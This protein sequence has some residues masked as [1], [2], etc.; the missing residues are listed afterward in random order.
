MYMILG[1]DLGTNSIGWAL[2]EKD[3]NESKGQIVAAGSRIIPMSQDILGKFDSG[4][5][6]SQTAERT[7]FRA[8]RRMRERQLLRRERLHRVLNVIGFLPEHY[9]AQIDF[10][11]HPG[12][13]LPNTEPKLPYKVS[14][15]GRV[16]FLFRNSFQEMLKDFGENQPQLVES[17]KSVPYDWTIYY[18][19]KKAL[20]RKIEKQELAWL[21]LQ[22]NQKRGYHQLRGEEEAETKN[23]IVEFH[24]LRVAEVEATQDKK[25][26]DE[27]W[28]N[29]HLEN[30]WIYKRTSKLPLDW[31]GK[32]KEF[33]VTTDLNEDGSVKKDKDGKEKRSLR[34]PA[35]E[36][37]TLVKKKTEH[38]LEKSQKTVGVYI[39]D[40]LLQ[41]PNQKIKGKLIR[42]VERSFYKTEL[43][44]IL[45]KQK[46]FHQELNDRNI[47]QLCLKELY[48]SNTIHRNSIVQKDIIHLFINDILF[49]QR[50]LKSK[51][52][53]ISNCK[54]ERRVFVQDGKLQS[55]PVKAIAKSNPLFQEFRLWKFVRSLRLYQL[56]KVVGNTL[57]TDVDVTEEF[58]DTE[59]DLVN[60]FAWL[61][62]KKEIDQKTF[63]KYPGFNLKK[64]AANYRWNYVEDRLYPCNETRFQIMSRLS[65]IKQI[66]KN[67]LN[68]EME[69]ALWHI[70][71]SVEDKT[72]IE[73]ALNTFA[74]R[75]E[76]GPEFVEVFRK[77]PAFKKEYSSL[78]AKAIKKLLSLMRTGKYW[79][80][81]DL[82]AKT[83]ERID[84]ILT[85]EYD[86]T[87]RDRVR[88]KAISLKSVADFKGLPEWLAS[89]I[90]YDR[91]SEEENILK[92]NTPN[93][94]TLL[95]QHS[96]RN[97]I[98]EQVI[99]ETLQ[100]V[101]DIWKQYGNGEKN[102]FAEIHVELGREMKNPA[103][104]RKKL[105][106]QNIE[107]ENTNLR[108][109]ALLAELLNDREVENVRPYS[110]M[111]QEILKIFE[112]GALN[113]AENIPEDILQIST[114][115]QPTPS[116]L[117]R[118]K[119]WLQQR[120]RSPYTGEIIPL[121][122]LFTRGYDIEHI[123]PQSRYFDDSL[124]NKV[125][126]ES[127]VNGEQYK[128][129]RTGYEFIKEFSGQI[130]EELSTRD[131]PVKVFTVEQ[132]E[133][134]VKENF[135]SSRAKMKRLLMEDIPDS[136]IQR[137]MNDSR[138]ISKVVKNLL[139]N[140]VRSEDEQEAVSKNL[141]TSNGS[142]TSTLRQHW[143]L[144]DIWNELITPRFEA[145]NNKTASKNFGDINKT[146]GKFLPQVPLELQKGFNKKRIDHRHHLLDAIIVACTSVDYINYLNNES[147]IGKGQTKDERINKRYDLRNKL[148]YKKYTD[149]RVKNYNWIFK[150]PW[151]TFTQETNETLRKVIV[152]FKQNLRVINKTSNRYYKWQPD[153]SGEFKKVLEYQTQK[154]RWSIRKPLHQATIS[155]NVQLK[156]RKIVSLSTA[157]INT[158]MIVD[159]SLK[160]AIR[161]LF[162]QNYDKKK[163][164]E[165]FNECN[166]QWNG[167]DLSKVEVY[168][169]NSANVAARDDVNGSFH[170]EKIKSITDTGI[171]AIMLR[172]LENYREEKG[173]T[174]IEHP[175]LAFSP[176]GLEKMNKNIIPL[177]NGKPHQPIY[178][179]RTY[180]PKGNKFSVG[181][182]GIKKQ[183]FAEAAKG[184]NLFYGIYKISNGKRN[185]E[186]I[187]L[188]V[189][190]ERRKQGLGP[191]PEKSEDGHSLLFYLSPNDLVY[192]PS[193]EEIS[194]QS[195]IHIYPMTKVLSARIYKVVSFTAGRLYCIP[196]YVAKPIVDKVEFTQLNKVEFTPEKD[197]I[198]EIC[199][200]L[201]TDRLGNIQLID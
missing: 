191:V 69:L 68:K 90:I 44:M 10:E 126:C 91:H 162:H 1:L 59:N 86:R 94:V 143:G 85:G 138:Y 177:N 60:L 57:R 197:S 159:K 52:S 61:N 156:L 6:I 27:I 200:K 80:E 124:S 168:Y 32:I 183:Q 153:H 77:F 99:N 47:Y 53:L 40:H 133:H 81:E 106:N 148:C 101:K 123:I 31:K 119:L 125:I 100:V 145:L 70:L 181:Q 172:H 25:N 174:I 78:S 122:K 11:K 140:I 112:E 34:A 192:V 4:Q 21:L 7:G 43:E 29:V 96:L 169:W 95:I 190:I 102:F 113:G 150:K 135:T 67:F 117:M 20:T 109:K 50:P 45:R 8:I 38:D 71:Y 164:I 165:F 63:L 194:D 75:N 139:S 132:Y 170:S 88:E 198:R 185:Y 66:S 56:E 79:K 64:S 149:E 33:I 118:Y 111:Q 166:N 167:K 151:E 127:V 18:L 48:R 13:F 37:W 51:K 179:V 76:I 73:K 163:I 54:Y 41:N 128:S 195:K 186:T 147:A 72:D 152:S 83:K 108:I 110:P 74:S 182:T 103:D 116:E 62:E 157:L 155:G 129:N 134:F 141:I 176:D 98:V 105:T 142:I 23:K 199:L 42:V 201:K 84:K 36:D 97:P 137:Q 187:P 46:E 82:D 14:A 136:F 144:N 184:T 104:R 120:Y 9:A 193:A 65:K 19:R 154:D 178:K 30:G 17:G 114:L 12:Q 196:H 180:E 171:Q 3:T 58:I 26:E 22:F 189:V 173:G 28:Y 2:I 160:M 161:K 175:E 158:E 92:W 121:N 15:D 24:S 35:E 49:Y 131:R 87:I 188:N 146:T 5:S 89:Y 107:N 39:Y 115:A 16:E 93:D 130:V 55:A